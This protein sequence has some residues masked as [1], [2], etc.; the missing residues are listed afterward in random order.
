MKRAAAAARG[1]GRT[2]AAATLAEASDEETA[3]RKS[4]HD[5]EREARRRHER[6]RS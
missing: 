1:K 2:D 3:A 5:A 6:A 4:F